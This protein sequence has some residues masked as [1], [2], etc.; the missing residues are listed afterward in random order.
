MR[1]PKHDSRQGLASRSRGATSRARGP[2]RMVRDSGQ[3]RI[4][5]HVCKMEVRFSLTGVRK[6]VVD[7]RRIYRANMQMLRH[8]A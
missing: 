6:E 5:H 3:F 1:L 7:L 8:V 4:V 2:P